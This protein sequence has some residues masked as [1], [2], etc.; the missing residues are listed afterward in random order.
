MCYFHD[1]FVCLCKVLS[2]HS[3]KL[4]QCCINS[5]GSYKLKEFARLHSCI[6]LSQKRYR[7]RDWVELHERYIHPSLEIKYVHENKYY[8]DNLLLLLYYG[9]RIHAKTKYYQ[10]YFS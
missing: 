6:I 2:I 3:I 9:Q 1:F 8:D 7:Y 10:E 4:E 5:V